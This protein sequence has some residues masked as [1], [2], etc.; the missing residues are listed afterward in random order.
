MSWKRL[1]RFV[2]RDG[3]IYRGEPIF[4][5][6]NYDVGKKYLAGDQ[7]KA[8]VI[9][10]TNIFENTIVTDEILE[11]VKLLGPLTPEDVPIVKC[12][13][14]NYTKHIEESGYTSTTLPSVVLQTSNLCSGL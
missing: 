14:L 6:T 12:I 9:K 8:K 1:I 7:L 10:G 11:V 13:G 3:K 4:T 2:A 5:D